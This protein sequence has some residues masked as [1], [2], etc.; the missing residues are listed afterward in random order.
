MLERKSLSA[1]EQTILPHLDAAHNLARWLTRDDADAEDIVQEACL[2]AFKFFGSYRGENSRSW[3]LAIV[4]NTYFTWRQQN[5][6]KNLTTAFDE[7]VHGTD[8]DI[9]TPEAILVNTVNVDLLKD[10][11]EKLPDEYREVVILRELEGLS[12]KEIADVANVP[13]GTVMSRL[14]RA[15]NQLQ[16]ALSGQMEKE[17]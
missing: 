16:Q 4:R 15:R 13:L 8:N 7:E 9:P 17:K 3:L 12:Y 2:R 10:A 1:F 5:R 11:L 6:I 14:A